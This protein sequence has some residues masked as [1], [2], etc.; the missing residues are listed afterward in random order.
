MT[1]KR[2]SKTYRGVYFELNGPYSFKKFKC[3]VFTPDVER[4]FKST[5]GVRRFIDKHFNAIKEIQNEPWP[6]IKNENVS[7][8]LTSMT[9]LESINF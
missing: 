4:Y 3:V 7:E 6:E 9:D 5:A 1:K 8:Y 2:K